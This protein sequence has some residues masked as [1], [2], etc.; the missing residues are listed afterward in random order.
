MNF[1]A[2]VTLAYGLLAQPVAPIQ[3]TVVDDQGKPVAGAEIALS[4]GVARDGSVS[5]VATTVTDLMGRFRVEDRG[6]FRSKLYR[7]GAI[8][9][10]K[11]GLA[12]GV[13]EL[14]REDQTDRTHRLVL[15][16]SQA[17]KITVRD[18]GGNAIKGARVAPRVLETD[19]TSYLGN[20][21]PDDW[22]ERLSTTTD[23]SGVA[24]L[25]ALTR[26]IKL[27]SVRITIP[28]RGGHFV[29]IPLAS[30]NDDVTLTLG[31]SSG[32]TGE[33]RDSSGKPI[34]G[35]D[36]E[37]WVRCGSAF[38]DQ[39]A[40]Y[41]IPERLRFDS[42]PIRTDALG[43]FKT[44]PVLLT[45][46]TYRT[47]IR[48]TGHSPAV[49]D[50]ITLRRES[51]SLGPIIIRPLRTI[52][53]RVVD[54]QGNPVAGVRIFEPAGGPF[55]MSDEAGRFR[56]EGARSGRWFVLAHRA[57][58]RF[59][60]RMVDSAAT[61]P[62]ELI[63]SRE[64]ERPGR[65]MATLPELISLEESRAL[66]RRLIAPYRKAATA[67]GDDAAKFRVL[68]IERWLNPAGLLEQVQKTRF[69]L[70]SSAD[71]LRG[72]AALALAA[73]DPEEAAAI[74]ETIADPGRRAGTL[75]DLVDALPATEK[76]RSSRC[77]IGQRSRRGRPSSRRTSFIRWGKLPNDGS[78][79]VKRRKR[80]RSLLRA[81]SSP[82]RCRH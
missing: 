79:W 23:E 46:S 7:E 35:A 69:D 4:P 67:K 57:G 71:F 16:P 20:S 56:L 76:A 30:A 34:A 65:I 64:H 51:N 74:A 13:V 45:G 19:R 31:E 62:I 60:G 21:L 49:S 77:S 32:L 25:P 73:Q 39:Q 52:S 18:A 27:R 24:S 44:A 11:P 53:G 68:D 36:V 48:A 5:I 15:E 29:T 14:I 17:R 43:S 9:A 40:S 42:G 2:L 50:W 54:R 80:R 70:G 61:E 55:T 66:A 26:R 37:V 78:S 1:L 58:F 41:G 59:D 28:A 75:V 8:W 10:H 33:I 47:V 6:V 22:L 72:R 82:K 81:G 38:G 63:L 3:G 12:I